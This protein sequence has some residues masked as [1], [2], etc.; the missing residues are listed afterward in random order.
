MGLRPQALFFLARCRSRW[1]TTI[2]KASAAPEPHGARVELQR[3][4][5][6]QQPRQRSLSPSERIVADASQQTRCSRSNAAHG[7]STFNDY[8]PASNPK[9]NSPALVGQL[10]VC[11]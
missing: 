1:E 3:Y 9:N 10:T 8:T 2:K 6:L 4:L 11:N 7:F 5:S